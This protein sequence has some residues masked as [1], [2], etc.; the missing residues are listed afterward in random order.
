MLYVQQ[1]E[2]SVRADV[3]GHVYHLR[4]GLCQELRERDELIL[5]EERSC[6][7]AQRLVE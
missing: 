3:E 4:Q 6:R 1:M 5:R 2:E 7:E